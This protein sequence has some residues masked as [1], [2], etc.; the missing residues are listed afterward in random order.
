MDLLRQEQ[1]VETEGCL[2]FQVQ[3]LSMPLEEEELP[4][5]LE[6]HKGLEVHPE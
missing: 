1:E 2:V 5:D 4:Q 6:Y 3:M